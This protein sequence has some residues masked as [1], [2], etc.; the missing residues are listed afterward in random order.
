VDETLDLFYLAESSP[1]SAVPRVTIWQLS[2]IPVPCIIAVDTLLKLNGE[3][4]V[5]SKE[6]VESL[7]THFTYLTF[8]HNPIDLFIEASPKDY[9]IALRG[10]LKDKN[11][12]GV[13]IIHTPS[14]LPNSR[15]IAETVVEAA[16]AYPYK[17]VFTIWMGGE[18]VIAAR[19]FLSSHGIP[20]F[21]STEQSVKSFMYMYRY[22]YNLRLLL[23]TPEV[24]LK[25]FEPDEYRAEEIIR[26]AS[27]EKRLFL[28]LNEVKDVLSHTGY[29]L[30]PQRWFRALKKRSR[31]P[32]SS[33]ILLC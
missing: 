12:D 10:C 26:K 13:L 32:I 28:N 2:R 5:L 23:E 27:E 18:Q 8:I 31:S 11:V 4:A 29:R 24:I 30:F 20:T 17:P 3:L 9:D 33:G 25:D 1:N 14:Y 6:T 16:K 19:E 7:R 15:E 21:V 22:D